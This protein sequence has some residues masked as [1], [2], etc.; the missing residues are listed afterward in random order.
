MRTILLLSI[1]LSACATHGV[2]CDQR[3]QPINLPATTNRHA[4]PGVP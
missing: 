2:R 4:A 3:L 1:L